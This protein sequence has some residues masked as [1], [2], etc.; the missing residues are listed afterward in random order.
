MIFERNTKK[1]K[2]RGHFEELSG[3]LQTEFDLYRNIV[4]IG[5]I[6]SFFKGWCKKIVKSGDAQ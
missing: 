5:Q 3:E 6:F 4:W 2:L 1:K